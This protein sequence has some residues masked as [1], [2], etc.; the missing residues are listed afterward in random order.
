MD[1]QQ[2]RLDSLDLIGGIDVDKGL[3]S[4]GKVY[5]S[6]LTATI[7]GVDLAFAGLEI[8]EERV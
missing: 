7:P 4:I 8:I 3:R 6:K 2:T 1:L 5:D